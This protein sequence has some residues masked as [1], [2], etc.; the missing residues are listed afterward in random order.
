MSRDRD[1]I[2]EQA[3]KHELRA[4]PP[5]NGELAL[6][7]FSEGGC[8][9]AETL[10]AWEDGGLNAAAMEAAEVHLSS[11]ARCQALAGTMARAIPV[12]VPVKSAEPFRLWKWWLAPIAAAT[13]AVTIWMVVPAER[14]AAVAP[15]TAPARDE[16]IARNEAI[17]RVEPKSK[18]IPEE[19]APVPAQPPVAADKQLADRLEQRAGV[20]AAP[21]KPIDVTLGRVQQRA[22]A[23]PPAA[24]PDDLRKR[25]VNVE[26]KKEGADTS[27]LM[28]ESA[29]AAAETVAAAAPAAAAAPPAPPA[30][31][32]A[33]APAPAPAAPAVAGFQTN[34][35][36]AFVPVEVVSPDPLSRWRSVPTGVERSEDGGRTWIP[37]RAAGTDII[38]GGSSPARTI[39]WLAGR[40]GLVLVAVDGFTFARVDLPE[41]LDIASITASDGRAATVTTADGRRFVTADS[42]R[43]WRQVQG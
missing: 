4:T 19:S 14:E 11:C 22:D 38:T 8:L 3:L 9:D 35:R 28:R 27:K 41:R 10:A 20:P 30:P 2:L 29:V 32:G 31:A 43:N 26:A 17:S 34:E 36:F 1:H 37:V 39:V 16:A 18:A 21:E 12:T 40:A 5:P 33:R 24:E 42:G 25:Q 6:R 13:A 7:S 15:P 23:S